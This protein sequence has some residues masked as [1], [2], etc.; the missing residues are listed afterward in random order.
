MEG[1]SRI[2]GFDIS[3]K[4][5]NSPPLSAID[6]FLFGQKNKKIKESHEFYSSNPYN[7]STYGSF[8]VNNVCEYENGTSDHQ[9]SL[10]SFHFMNG[11]EN[12]LD[13][14]N[15]N[16]NLVS[17]ELEDKSRRS[18]GNKGD[19]YS[20]HLIK[21]QWTDEEDRKLIR[22]VN[23]FG[24]R[25]WAQIAGKISGRA[26]KQCRE[27]WHNHLRPDIKKDNW[28]AEEENLLIEA[29]Q[30]LGNKWADIAKQI[31]GRTENSIKNHW[32][33][34]KRR[35]N[36]RR[37]NK[38]S[39]SKNGKLLKPSPLQ[40]YIKTKASQEPRNSTTLS[41]FRNITMS[42][43][44]PSKSTSVSK[45][46]SVNCMN[47]AIPQSPS[48]DSTSIITQTCDD[49]LKF[50]QSL[51]STESESSAVAMMCN[52]N[53]ERPDV[54]RPDHYLASLWGGM[55]TEST[56]SVV[57]NYQG[58]N[59]SM[60]DLYEDWTKGKKEMDLIEMVSSYRI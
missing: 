13:W 53:H 16:L 30:R 7:S 11:I 9:A 42:S 35:Q 14:S 2:L 25:K 6:R 24:E 20:S 54:M 33:A 58:C 5:I 22:L 46:P 15:N 17:K 8:Q 45:A 36:S 59:D 19:E 31:P 26:G 32:N 48:E 50:M 44:N 52:N 43:A 47:L 3:Q 10:G 21:G 41:S 38:K 23:Q 12:S 39:G 51:F 37:K 28:S 56:S 1:G 57:A 29:H 4:N 60:A 55:A 34:T 40:E 49:E 18:Y 27:R